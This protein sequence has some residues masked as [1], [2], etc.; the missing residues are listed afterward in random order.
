MLVSEIM[1]KAFSRRWECCKKNKELVKNANG[2]PHPLDES[3]APQRSMNSL[4]C[5]V[6]SIHTF[7]SHTARA[8]SLL[9][10]AMIKNHN[11]ARRC[12]GKEK[13][14]N[15]KTSSSNYK[16]EKRNFC[17]KRCLLVSLSRVSLDAIIKFVIW[18]VIR[19][20][21]HDFVT[22]CSFI[23]RACNSFFHHFFRNMICLHLG[24]DEE[25]WFNVLLWLS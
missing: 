7:T 5:Q 17:L 13:T 22:L 24:P 12:G 10:V 6:L 11:S 1:G 2:I 25:T 18:R 8:V 16:I 4:A 9:F 20:K 19:W 3:A 21:V 23:K 15:R 14:Q